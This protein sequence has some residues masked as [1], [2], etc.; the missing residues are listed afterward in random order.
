MEEP[1]GGW[2]GTVR[3]PDGREY[4]RALSE[5]VESDQLGKAAGREFPPGAEAL[6]GGMSRRNFLRLLSASAAL[7]GVG[8]CT[9]RPAEKI[10]PYVSRPPELT[11]GIPLHYATS[12][13][14]GGYATGLLVE[15]HEGRPTKV[16]GNPEHPAS[17]GA[18]G[19]Y[20]QASVLQLYDPHRARAVRRGNR[21]TT[22][23]DLVRS[24][25]P[26]QMR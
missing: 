23:S 12:M 7:A 15:S 20:E 26:D 22:W 9:R 18:A 3:Q 4:W 10:L 16:E 11:P 8:A 21:A 14:L 2:S 5:L 25:A 1:H 17:L 13:V 6:P 19:V 24:L